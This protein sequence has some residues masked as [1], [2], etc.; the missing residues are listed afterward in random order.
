MSLKRKAMVKKIKSKLL[1]LAYKPLYI[2]ALTAQLY[3]WS[4]FHIFEPCSPAALMPVSWYS[5]F[6]LFQPFAYAIPFV[7]ISLSPLLGYFPLFTYFA[8]FSLNFTPSG[9]CVRDFKSI[10]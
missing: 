9:E 5:M 10:L 2:L 6:C 7:E 4:L 8:G 1:N 3:P